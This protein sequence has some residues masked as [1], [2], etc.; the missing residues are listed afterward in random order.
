MITSCSDGFFS[1]H[2]RQ[3]RFM[4]LR[5]VW[6][7]ALGVAVAVS[8][9]ACG[10]SQETSSTSATPS[11]SG[12]AGGQ[13]VDTSKAGSIKGTAV[14]DGAAPEN[15][16]IKMNAD[17]VCLREA[18]GEQR[19][20]TFLVGSDGKSLANVFV[21][22]K[23]GL[24]PY[25]FD[26][27]TEVATID[28]KE[29]R[30]HPHVFGMRVGQPLQI[31]NSDPTL[32]NIHAVPKANQEFNHGQPIQGMKMNH[33][34]TQKEVMVPFKCD[35]HGWMNAYVGVL[36]HPYFAVTDKDGKF[37]LKDVPAGTYTIEAWH[38][39][40]GAMTQSVTLGE[41]ESKDANFTFKAPAAATN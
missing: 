19:Q 15:A 16:V 6:M 1:G 28:Q 41:K 29:C 5:N 32:H 21:Y 40:G 37:E 34:F 39:R 20:E 3:E 2:F 23:D 33:T 25:S 17:P 12:A 31:I 9:A 26:V 27:P 10:G 14:L 13:K 38:E 18:K 30:Y 36:D 11:S 4:R 22:I 24:G 8:V 7:H 35:V